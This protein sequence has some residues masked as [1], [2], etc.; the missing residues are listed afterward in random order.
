MRPSDTPPSSSS[1]KKRRPKK[2]KKKKRK[3]T[4]RQLAV[5]EILK[6]DKERGG[7]NSDPVTLPNGPVATTPGL[8]AEADLGHRADLCALIWKEYPDADGFEGLCILEEMLVLEAESAKE[9]EFERSRAHHVVEDNFDVGLAD[10]L[11]ACGAQALREVG[12]DQGLD[13]A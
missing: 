4:Q 12:F 9:A 10:A 13:E 6:K 5:E 1:R 7:P 3:K 11:H 8:Y 2:K